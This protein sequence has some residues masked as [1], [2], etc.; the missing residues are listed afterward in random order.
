M[1]KNTNRVQIAH[2]NTALRFRASAKNCRFI[3]IYIYSLRERLRTH[4]VFT[5]DQIVCLV[6]YL[7]YHQFSIKL[8]V[9]D[10]YLNR[11][12]ETFLIHIHNICLH[13][14]ILKNIIFM[15]PPFEEC[16]RALSVAHVRPSVRACVRRNRCILVCFKSWTLNIDFN[17]IYSVDTQV[18]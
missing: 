9:V 13:G 7:K 17:E 10:V 18:D 8:Y 1:T 16:G 4:K 12:G 3:D 2:L 15:P 14:E 11:L 6:F 5:V